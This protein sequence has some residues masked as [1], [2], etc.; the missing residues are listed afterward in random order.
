M[1]YVELTIV[2]YENTLFL[3]FLHGGSGFRVGPIWLITCVITQKI[4]LHT[5][6]EGKNNDDDNFIIILLR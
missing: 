3:R 2:F 4:G 5:N 6:K 1:H